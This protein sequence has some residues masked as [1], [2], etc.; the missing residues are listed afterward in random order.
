MTGS[1]TPHVL[2]LRDI[3]AWQFPSLALGMQN[4]RPPIVAAIPSLQRGAVWKPQ[5]VELLW[6]SILRGFPIGALVISPVLKGQETRPGKYG[7]G[8]AEAAINHHLLDGQQRCNAIALGFQD[9]FETADS[10]PHTTLWL[11]MQPAGQFAANSSRA[12]LLRLCTTAHP[13]GYGTQDELEKL[14]A[15]QVREALRDDYG[16]EHKPQDDDYQRP[17]PRHTWPYKANVPIPLAW[18]LKCS[19]DT[20]VEQLRAFLRLRLS[21]RYKLESLHKRH[22]ARKAWDYLNQVDNTELQDLARALHTAHR[23]RL[24][25]LTVAPKA[26]SRPTRQEAE[27]AKNAQGEQRIANVEHLFQRLNS[28][29]TELRGDELL[30]SMIKAYWPGIEATI[31]CMPRRPPATQVALLGTRV[32]LSDEEQGRPRGPL[33][34]S[35]LRAIAHPLSDDA[36]HMQTAAQHEKTQQHER[37]QKLIKQVFALHEPSHAKHADIVRILDIVDGWLLYDPKTNPWGMPPVL[38]SRMAEKCPEMLFFLMLVARA[39]IKQPIAAK[40]E[41]SVRRRLLGLATAV[42]WFGIDTAGAVRKLWDMQPS[43]TAWLT[44]SAF[45]GVLKLIKD[46]GNDKSG[47]VNLRSPMGLAKIIEVPQRSTLHDWDWWNTLIVAPANGNDDVQDKRRIRYWP[48]LEKLRDCE[49]LLVYCQRA[50][51]A[52]RF[53]DY[54]RYLG[55]YWDEHNRPWDFDHILPQKTFTDVRNA[56]FLRVC[57]QWGYTIGNLHILRFE[58]N[59]SRQD[60]PATESIANEHLEMAWLRSKGGKD[61]RPAFSIDR[62]AVRGNTSAVLGFVCAARTRLLRLYEEW[63]TQLD[64][65]YMLNGVNQE[66]TD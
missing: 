51:M 41:A 34:V 45:D 10:D 47:I 16:W 56:R 9:P 49:P 26:L 39:S 29:G 36:A 21:E 27:H 35:Q 14:S 28:G 40:H 54:D 46:L 22:W 43:A 33:S 64:I 57:Q 55:D 12:Y 59:R 48:L 7:S 53:P 30:Y 44:P 58:E 62:E 24:V 19:A 37:E 52:R 61:L 63:Y 38:R 13:W 25:A 60:S 6:D 42:H 18:L 23:M 2:S 20:E 65:E 32:A 4:D 5:Q 31:D 66:A 17:R 1:E 3:A 11:D 50:W 15:H 8:W